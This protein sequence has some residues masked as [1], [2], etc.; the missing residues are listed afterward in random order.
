MSIE[1][2][3]TKRNLVLALEKAKVAEDDALV[4]GLAGM[5]SCVEPDNEMLRTAKTVCMDTEVI[6]D[7]EILLV[8]ELSTLSLNMEVTTELEDRQFIWHE[9]FMHSM[10]IEFLGLSTILANKIEQVLVSIDEDWKDLRPF[11]ESCRQLFPSVRQSPSSQLI[12][13]TIEP[14]MSHDD[15]FVYDIFIPKLAGAVVS[16][17]TAEQQKSQVPSYSMVRIS[18]DGGEGHLKDLIWGDTWSLQVLQE[19]RDWVELVLNGRT[20][21][22]ATVNDQVEPSKIDGNGQVWTPRPGLWTFTVDG[23]TY[24]LQLMK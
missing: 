13:C 2:E 20:D 16:L 11:A 3:K 17:P 9:L 6:D 12:A 22:T 10:A 7:L 1:I 15:S 19:D 4:A 5:V 14:K 23:E 18:G 21:A 8:R 24:S